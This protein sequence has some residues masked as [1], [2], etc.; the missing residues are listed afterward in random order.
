MTALG[1][2]S[3]ANAVMAGLD[4]AIHASA[5][6]GGGAIRRVDARVKPAHDGF[7]LSSSDGAAA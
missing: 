1:N 7:L 4:P 5:A 6:A 3:Q 2:P